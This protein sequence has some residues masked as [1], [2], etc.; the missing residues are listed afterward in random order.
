M[1]FF[2]KNFKV[3]NGILTFYA[4]VF[5]ISKHFFASKTIIKKLVKTD[6]LVLSV[7]YRFVLK[8]NYHF[9]FINLSCCDDTNI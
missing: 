5:E 3:K 6:Y 2:K 1:K 8:N 4:I 7:I 9:S